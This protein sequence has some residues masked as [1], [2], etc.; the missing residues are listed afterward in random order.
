MAK[1]EPFFGDNG[2]KPLQASM[3]VMHIMQPA[4]SGLAIPVSAKDLPRSVSNTIS[5]GTLHH[6][7]DIIS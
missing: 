4:L 3:F 1:A 7:I 2:R 5:A 6:S